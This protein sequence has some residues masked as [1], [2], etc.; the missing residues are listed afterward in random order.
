MATPKELDHDVEAASFEYGVELTMPAQ[1]FQLA[2]RIAN[3]DVTK[4]FYEK[5]REDLRHLAL[6][7]IDGEDAKD[8][9]DAVHCERNDKEG[10]NLTVAIADVS[11]FIDAEGFLDQEAF[12]RGT[13][14]YFPNVVLP[15]FPSR[16]S[17]DLCSLKPGEDRLGLGFQATVDKK[18]KL[19]NGRFF[20]CVICS[21]KRL[22]YQQAQKILDGSHSDNSEVECSLHALAGLCVVLEDVRIKR[23]GLLMD[24]PTTVPVLANG[25]VTGFKEEKR[26]F[27]HR[28]IE[29]CMLLANTSAA[30]FLSEKG[31]PFLYRVHPKPPAEKVAR[32]RDV[33]MGMGIRCGQINTATDLMDVMERYRDDSSLVAQVMAKNVLRTLESAVYTPD[34]IGHFGLGYKQYAHFTSP[35]R[36]YPDLTVH[37]AIKAAIKGESPPEGLAD[38]LREIG[39]HC[40]NREQA[41]DRASMNV[42]SRKLGRALLGKIGKQVQGVISGMAR[43]GMFVSMQGSVDGLVRFSGLD[44]YYELNSTMTKAVGRRKK[45]TFHVGMEVSVK[46][47]EVSREDGRCL[48]QLA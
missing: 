7:T 34:N 35:I 16:L 6:V 14:V 3:Q 11:S 13:S 26:T 5:D 15:M 20:N 21:K 19:N 10:F 8:F 12:F 30:E 41:A 36:R 25:K 22:T 46:I 40:T 2:E 38:R 43:G 44:D 27:A 18:G 24:I 42:I 23:G 17:E 37:R 48:L 39:A 4:G 33:L 9:D 45:R 47:A 29:E 31:Y 1:A 28:I 32:L